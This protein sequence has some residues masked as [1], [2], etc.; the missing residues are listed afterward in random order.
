[1]SFDD[2]HWFITGVSSG[3]GRA[4]AEAALAAGHRVVGTVRRIEQLAHFEKLSPGRAM[5]VRM[6][7]TK[8]ASVAAGVAAAARP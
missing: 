5:A 3:I 7:V 8:P 6:D 1:M 2:Q 4:T